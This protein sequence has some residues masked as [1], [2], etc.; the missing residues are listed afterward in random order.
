[1]ARDEALRN[2][3]REGKDVHRQTAARIFDIAPDSVSPEQRATAKTIN[4]GV[5]YGM[6]AVNLGR[7]LGISTREASRFISSYF[8]RYPGVQSF[9]EHTQEKARSEL[10]VETLTGR[11]RPVPEIASADHRTRSFGERIA[12]NTPIQGTAADVMKLAMIA[13][14]GVLRERGLRGRMILTVHDEL[15]FDCPRDELDELLAVVV[16]AMEEAMALD[17]PLV[18]ETGYGSNWSEAH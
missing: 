7:S 2:A 15:L 11:R 5:I 18:V 6:G 10:T 14:D 8:E 1:M 4:F 3:F 12:V 13:V 17:V 16:P 9:I